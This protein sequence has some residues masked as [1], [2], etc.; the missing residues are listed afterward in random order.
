[1]TGWRNVG[2]PRAQSVPIRATPEVL[3]RLPGTTVVRGL[4]TALGS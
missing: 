2:A 4:T 1:M 3:R